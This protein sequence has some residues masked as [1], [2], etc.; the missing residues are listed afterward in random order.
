MPEARLIAAALL[1]AV[2]A[3]GLAYFG[4]HERGIG[5]DQDHALWMAEREANT[6]AAIA[7][8]QRQARVTAEAANEAQ[9]LANLSRAS[10]ARAA[11]A[12]QRLL[13]R[14]RIAGA[15]PATPASPGSDAASAPA[16][17]P[18]ELLGMALQ[19]AQ[20]YARTADERGIAG[21]ACVSAVK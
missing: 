7:E 14:A 6:A 17:V 15:C 12:G 1:C 5:R 9:R 2:L 8:T 11:D 19:L 18:A 10:A 4:Y 21:A 16:R 20:V 13:D 3:G